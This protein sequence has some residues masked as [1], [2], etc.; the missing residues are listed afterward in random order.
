[1]DRETV[2]RSYGPRGISEGE[3]LYR[4]ADY[5]M[6]NRPEHTTKNPLNAVEMTRSPLNVVDD[7]GNPRKPGHMRRKRSGYK[8]SSSRS[9][10]PRLG[11]LETEKAEYEE[12][13]KARPGRRVEAEKSRKKM[14]LNVSVERRSTK[15][16]L[17]A[18]VAKILDDIEIQRRPLIDGHRRSC[19]PRL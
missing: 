19:R 16:L 5:N 4:N 15:R 1:M 2:G 12:E 3:G 9:P 6:E 17:T 13:I 8:Y 18:T 14:N 10:G 11:S 7:E